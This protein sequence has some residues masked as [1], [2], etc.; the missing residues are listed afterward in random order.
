MPS[1]PRL[2]GLNLSTLALPFLL[3]TCVDAMQFWPFRR[4]TGVITPR[5]GVTHLTP[6]NMAENTWGFTAENL[7]PTAIGGFWLLVFTLVAW[8]WPSPPWC[9]DQG[10]K[11]RPVGVHASGFSRQVQGSYS[12][13]GIAGG[14]APFCW[15]IFISCTHRGCM[16]TSVNHWD[17]Y[18]TSTGAGSMLQVF[19]VSSTSELMIH[20][21]KL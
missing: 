3:T 4:G 18:Q 16:K 19:F 15:R 13:D 20:P 10:C 7:H 11:L 14:E 6:V 12:K 9:L 2:T 17:I 1:C 21:V 8:F 5:N